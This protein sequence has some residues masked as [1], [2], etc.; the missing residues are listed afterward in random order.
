MTK[1][2]DIIITPPLLFCLFTLIS[3]ITCVDPNNERA[4]SNKEWYEK[5]LEEKRQQQQQEQE[6][7]SSA[8]VMTFVNRRNQETSPD[9]DKYERLCRGEQTRVCTRTVY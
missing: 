8:G 1:V 7:E 4:A 5:M 9:F 3:R 2:L 6:G